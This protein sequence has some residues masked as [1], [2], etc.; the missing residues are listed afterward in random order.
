MKLGLLPD[1]AND[2]NPWQDIMLNYR[3]EWAELVAGWVSDV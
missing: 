1:P 3:S 2:P